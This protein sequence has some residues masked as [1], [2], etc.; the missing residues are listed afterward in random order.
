MPRPAHVVVDVSTF[1]S[2]A[3]ALKVFKRVCGD[4][5]LIGELKK[6]EHAL[7]RAQ[8]RRRKRAISARHR[9]KVAF[10]RARSLAGRE[11]REEVTGI[12]A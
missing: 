2:L 12:A 11:R 6:R 7:S 3:T 4:C 8:A 5:G 9:N 1:E 10:K